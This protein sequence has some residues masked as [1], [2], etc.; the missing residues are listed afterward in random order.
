MADLDFSHNV[1]GIPEGAPLPEPVKR[2]VSAEVI[3]TPDYQ[4]AYSNYADNTNWMSSIGSSVAA[5]SSNAIAAKLGGELGKQPQGTLPQ[6]TDFDKTMN[7]SYTTQAHATLGLQADKLIT[8]SNIEVSKAPRLTPELIQ[9]TNKQVSLGLQ[10]IFANAPIEIKPSLELQYKGQQLNQ[11]SQLADRMVSQNKQDRINN[12]DL[13]AKNNSQA[14]YSLQLSSNDLDKNGDSKSALAAYAALKKS[15]DAAVAIGDKT[16]VERD[17]ALDSA[18]QAR[19][20]AKYIRAGLEAQNNRTEEAFRKNLAEKPPTDVSNEDHAAVYQN[21]IAYLNNQDALKSSDE[22]LKSQLMYNRIITE[23]DKITGAEWATFEQSVSPIQAAQMKFHLIQAQNKK[24]STEMDVN[25][26]I[27]NYSDP[28]SQA[29]ATPEVKNAAFNKSVDYMIRQNPNMTRD[30]AEV[31]VSM[32]AGAPAPVFTKTLQNRLW[33]GDAQQMMGAARQIDALQLSG[34][35]HALQEL[36]ENDRAIAS[37]I[38]HNY[39]NADPAWAARVVTENKQNQDPAIRK[40]TET[41]WS[42]YVYDNTIKKNVSEND[43]ILSQFGLQ[44]GMWHKGFDSPWAK[45]NYAADIMDVY[46]TNFINTRG[47]Q[48][49]SQM[50][51]QQY[52]NN[53]YGKTR[54]NGV[55]ELAKHPIEKAIGLAEGQGIEAINRDI[56]RQTAIPMSKLREAYNN[57][58]TNEY[59]SIEPN[60]KSNRLDFVKH[61]RNGNSTDTVKYPLRLV[62]NNFNWE[63]NVDTDNGP[64]SVFLAAPAIG[65]HQY[66][67]DT[68]WIRK[69]AVFDAQIKKVHQ[70]YIGRA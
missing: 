60:E 30:E 25:D 57:K 68:A 54:I 31:Q 32:T 38:S 43:F 40:Q 58:M 4:S 22:N 41:A 62:G 2:S 10:N 48:V 44:G 9:K 13:S 47:D 64:M 3:Q 8:D 42:S 26:L 63:L 52:I 37:D 5:S 1:S 45:G 7:E 49:R 51:T 12:L 50:L 24:Q 11:A 46:R 65:V 70:N 36:N 19:L 39:N 29:N 18:R 69:Q 59:W 23:P 6:F 21:V 61:T 27:K 28:R 35:G 16:P 53:N 56:V 67:P 14:T 33:S 34:N 55:S 15:L 20:S 17:V 66:T